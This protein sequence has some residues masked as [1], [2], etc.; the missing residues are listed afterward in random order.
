MDSWV[1]ERKE[2]HWVI[3]YLRYDSGLRVLDYGD[4]D[5]GFDIFFFSPCEF[6]ELFLW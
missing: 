4:L 6:C 1:I 5:V 3:G 2:P